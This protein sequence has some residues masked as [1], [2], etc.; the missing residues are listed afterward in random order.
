MTNDELTRFLADLEKKLEVVGAQAHKASEQ[1]RKAVA[2][3][4]AVRE[5]VSR[6]QRH[7]ISTTETVEYEAAPPPRKQPRK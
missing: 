6:V 2:L 7:V 3:L 4:N 1:A 5:E